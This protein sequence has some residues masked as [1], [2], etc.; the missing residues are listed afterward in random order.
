[1]ANSPAACYPSRG[2][3]NLL[4]TKTET[5]QCQGVIH[6][7]TCE[8]RS[9]PYDNPKQTRLRMTTMKCIF[10]ESHTSTWLQCGTVYRRKF[11]ENGTSVQML[12]VEGVCTHQLPPGGKAVPS[13]SC[14]LYMSTKGGLTNT[15]VTAKAAQTHYNAREVDPSVSQRAYLNTLG[16]R[17]TQKHLGRKNRL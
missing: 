13:L 10:D 2:H 14:H 5:K 11:H 17:L 1:M 9:R 8:W 16:E 7:T 3:Y 4:E 12:H 6:C 15:R